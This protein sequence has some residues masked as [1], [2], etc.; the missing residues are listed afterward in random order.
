MNSKELRRAWSK[1]VSISRGDAPRLIK[2]LFSLIFEK[3]YTGEEVR[4]GGFGKFVLE[5]RKTYSNLLKR[6]VLTK[7]VIFVPSPLTERNDT[8]A[9]ENALAFAKEQGKV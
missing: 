1:R 5:E 9:I 8:N 6:V 7:R 3:V 2:E 4:I